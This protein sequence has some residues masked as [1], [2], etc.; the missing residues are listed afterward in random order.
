MGTLHGQDS[1]SALGSDRRLFAG[2]GENLVLGA[3]GG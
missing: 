1:A 2:F 3:P